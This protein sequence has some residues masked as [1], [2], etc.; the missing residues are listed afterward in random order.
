MHPVRSFFL[1]SSHTIGSSQ[2]LALS[3]FILLTLKTVMGLV[4]RGPRFPR[5]ESPF[6]SSIP[7]VFVQQVPLLASV[8]KFS[9]PEFGVCDK[10]P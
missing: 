7:V 3:R 2:W 6:Q 10:L 1:G 8:P 9:V 5:P 4:T